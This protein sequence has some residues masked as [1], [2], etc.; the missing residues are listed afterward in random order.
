MERAYVVAPILM[1]VA[2]V[3]TMAQ[4]AP[5][6]L[7]PPG[8]DCSSVPAGSQRAACEE[9]QLGPTTG[10]PSDDR[11]VTGAEPATPGTV[12][13]PTVPDQPDGESRGS[14]SGTEGGAGGIG[15]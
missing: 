12:S 11:P 15:N 13:P 8:Y 2:P 5:Q 6:P 3:M 14:G 10:N 7:Y 9:S 1:L 4:D